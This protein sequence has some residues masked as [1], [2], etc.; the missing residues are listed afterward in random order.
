MYLD[1]GIS[2]D[3]FH[4]GFAI[5]AL[6]HKNVRSLRPA[7]LQR[8]PDLVCLCSS[9]RLLVLFIFVHAPSC[10]MPGHH[11][12]TILCHPIRLRV[13]SHNGSSLILIH[14]SNNIVTRPWV[15]V[16]SFA[17]HRDAPGSSLISASNLG[18]ALLYHV[19]GCSHHVPGCSLN[20]HI[21]QPGCP[22]V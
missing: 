8:N 9:Y 18:A 5:Q 4:I 3:G 21:V 7:S 13:Q 20:V 10:L 1:I 14:H 17:W 6:F 16:R 19:P 15:H 22:W 12:F 2:C 11:K